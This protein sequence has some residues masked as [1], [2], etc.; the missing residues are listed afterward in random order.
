MILPDQVWLAVDPVDMRL[1]I[2]GLS[3]G[4]HSDSLITGSLVA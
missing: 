1:G 4:S 2:D 3:V